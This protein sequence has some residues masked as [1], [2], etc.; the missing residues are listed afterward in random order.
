MMNRKG[1]LKR[2]LGLGAGF[3]AAPALLNSKDDDTILLEKGWH[4]FTTRHNFETGE[5]ATTIRDF[6][7]PESEESYLLRMQRYE[8]DLTVRNGYMCQHETYWDGEKTPH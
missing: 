2:I 1:F 6:C 8:K 5:S 4:N 7:Q 3:F